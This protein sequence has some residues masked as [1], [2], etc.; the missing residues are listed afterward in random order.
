M[1]DLFNVSN[2][3]SGLAFPASL[4]EEF[5]PRVLADFVG[6]E[7]PKKILANLLKSPRPCALL[8]CGP[9]GCG[10]TSISLAFASELNA[11][12]HHVG[13]QECRLDV[14]QNI[15]AMCQRVAFNFKT[16]KP[17]RYHVV[18][19]D[20][21]DVMS[22]AAQKYLLSKL[23]ATGTCPDTIWIF[24]CNATDR[25]EERFLS[26]TLR[27]DFNSYGSSQEI[28]DLLAKIWTLKAPSAPVP[29]LKKLACG[30]VRE[31][32]QR[33]ELELLAV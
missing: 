16:G 22:D 33:L 3:Q 27:L 14:L 5:R 2:P 21:A 32:L 26:R 31:S 8:F 7:K 19:V 6:L 11:E 23:D 15:C 12:L 28:T 13:S 17:A 10:K 18:L 1:G 25:L 29:N 4:T 9:P 20:E 30:N 24:T